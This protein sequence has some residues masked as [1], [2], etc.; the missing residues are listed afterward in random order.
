MRTEIIE[1][2]SGSLGGIVSTAFGHPLD[3]IKM[4]RQVHPN[5]YKS[6]LSSGRSIVAKEGVRSLFKGVM[7]PVL[8]QGCTNAI[9]FGSASYCNEHLNMQSKYEKTF[10]SGMIA[11]TAVSMVDCPVELV[12]TQLQGQGMG[13]L[14]DGTDRTMM[15]MAQLMVRHNGVRGLYQVWIYVL[16][17]SLTYNFRVSFLLCG[18]MFPLMVSSFLLMLI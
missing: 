6:T 13:R 17:W 9:L 4:R 3:T 8:A 12:K 15:T 16:G 11:G 7:P 1:I 18:E 14:K 5:L 10:Y 2:V